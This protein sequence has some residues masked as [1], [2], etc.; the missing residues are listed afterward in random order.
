V[1]QTIAAMAALSLGTSFTPLLT[2]FR[3]SDTADEVGMSVSDLPYEM[4]PFYR[5]FSTITIFATM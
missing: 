2:P 4:Y 3:Q 1:A 5:L